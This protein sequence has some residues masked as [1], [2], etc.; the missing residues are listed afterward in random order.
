[1]KYIGL[2]LILLWGIP[3]VAGKITPEEKYRI[4]KRDFDEA[5][6]EKM[7]VRLSSADN[8]I[9]SAP[10]PKKDWGS[11]ES[12]TEVAIS[13]GSLPESEL[14]AA[15]NPA[16]STNIVVAAMRQNSGS[17]TDAL[18]FPI[19]S[20]QDFGK[21]WRQSNYA[22]ESP[23]INLLRVGGGDPMFIYDLYGKNLYFTWIDLS[24][25]FPSF[26]TTFE[27]IWL[28]RSIDGGTS[29]STSVTNKLAGVQLGGILS[30]SPG[31]MID[32]EWMAIDR[33]NSAFRGTIYGSYLT[34][35]QTDTSE[36]FTITR[37]LPGAINF[38]P[39]GTQ[40]PT[41]NIATIQ[42][43][44]LDVDNSGNV[45]MTFMGSPDART[46]Y[47]YHSVS[48]DGGVTFSVPNII[49][50]AEFPTRSSNSMNRYVPGIDSG[51]QVPSIQCACGRPGTSNAGDIYCVWEAL[52][53]SKPGNSGEDIYF[54]RSTDNGSSWS[55][56][57]V[58]NQDPPGQSKHQFRP[59]I[60]VG[61]K[62]AITIGWYDGREASDNSAVH[63]YVANS[64]DGGK[65]FVGE[66]KVTSVPTDFSTVE[67]QAAHFGIGEYLQVIASDHYNIPIWTD[68]RTDDGS[69]TVYSAFSPITGAPA[70]VERR[71]SITSNT[72]IVPNPAAEKL[73]VTFEIATQSEVNVVL[74]NMLGKQIAGITPASFDAGRHT[75]TIPLASVAA[76]SYI[77]RLETGEGAIDRVVEV[78]K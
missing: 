14:H 69:L 23:L 4:V 45:H 38:L 77:L 51:R 21:T 15:I 19:Y 1:M 16:D 11:I 56:P 26:D 68:G 48:V 39:T 10:S 29:F 43:G 47:V 70:A 42:I 36:T 44:T 55:A 34:I 50:R 62:G 53:I 2:L 72:S 73:L 63:Y 78:V 74:V 60:F 8:P 52:G 32:K 17:L 67:E 49:S 25:N 40:V 9:R 28:A 33:S 46:Y 27:E 24:T 7:K 76:G 18:S 65:T 75:I 31:S 13:D 3:A 6:R 20:T 30:Q 58:V 66:T 12:V 37:I 5:L 57:L 35:D 22:G 61:K 41:K 59:S 64:F 54:A 71:E